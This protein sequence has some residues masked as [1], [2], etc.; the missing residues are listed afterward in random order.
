MSKET[1]TIQKLTVLLGNSNIYKRYERE[2]ILEKVG[3]WIHIFNIAV[4][5]RY[6]LFN[7]YIVFNTLILFSPLHRNHKN[8]SKCEGQRERRAYVYTYFKLCNNQNFLIVGLLI[9]FNNVLL[10]TYII[11][12]DYKYDKQIN[13][14]V[15]KLLKLTGFMN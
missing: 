2:S 9:Y 4:K 3:R 13:Y 10:H 5:I 1:A 14:L 7:L 15:L 12:V 8:T 11:K 6:I